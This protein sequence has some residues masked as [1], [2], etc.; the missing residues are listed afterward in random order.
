DFDQL[1]VSDVTQER[2]VRGRKHPCRANRSSNKAWLGRGTVVVS[3][4]ACNS[5]RCEIYLVGERTETILVKFQ[6]ARSKRISFEDIATGLKEACMNLFDHRWF[7]ENE[8]LIAP[9]SCLT[10]VILSGKLIALYVGTHRP[11]VDENALS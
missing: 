3:K 11:I 5:C 1:L 8:V 2:I 6:A 7:R 4:T 9:L 10:A